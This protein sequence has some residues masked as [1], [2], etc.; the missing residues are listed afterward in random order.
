MPV[1]VVASLKLSS[2]KHVPLD[3]LSLVFVTYFPDGAASALYGMES[4]GLWT[5]VFGL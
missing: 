3:N 4:I 2:E 1:P 5:L